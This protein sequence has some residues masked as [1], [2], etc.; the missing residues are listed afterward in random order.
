M[1]SSIS[2]VFI[3]STE[4]VAVLLLEGCPWRYT[5]YRIRPAAKP[6]LTGGGGGARDDGLISTDD[7]EGCWVRSECWVRKARRLEKK[8]VAKSSSAMLDA[9]SFEHLNLGLM[10]KLKRLRVEKKQ[11]NMHFF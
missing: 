9:V 5:F 7:I 8:L 3:K 11:K 6:E 4:H 10:L 2:V 1:T